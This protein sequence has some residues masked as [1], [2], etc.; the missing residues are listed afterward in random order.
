MVFRWFIAMYLISSLCLFTL[1]NG[2]DL[3]TEA[4]GVGSSLQ[5]AIND[6]KR[7]AV[8]QCIGSLLVSET[9]I[10]NFTL[11]KDIILVKTV[12]AVKRVEVLSETKFAEDSFSVRIRAEVST[13]SIREDLV[14][15]QILLES[16]NKPRLMVLVDE[17]DPSTVGTSLER[18]LTEKGFDL[19]DNTALEGRAQL[20]QNDGDAARVGELAGAEYIIT[21]QAE[22]STGTG[23]YGMISG[24]VILSVRI[25][26]CSTG[27]ILATESGDASFAHMDANVALSKA[28]ERVASSV[29]NDSLLDK[30]IVSFQDM[31]NNGVPVELVVQNVNNY[32]LK[33]HINGLLQTLPGVVSVRQNGFSAG[34]ASFT[35]Y[36]KG[37][38]DSLCGGLDGKSVDLGGT[39]S[40]TDVIG[41]R[42]MASLR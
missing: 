26:N 25:I 34:S 22:K 9:E 39:F 31:V 12:G 29:F 14:A 3:T 18:Y 4:D 5:A 40:I 7:S 32:G 27:K 28:S 13:G 42:V 33:N 19:L 20:L 1:G 2:G 11:K 38:V 41:S 35:V 37:A 8:E 10:E 21:G 16:M 23:V 15:M 6:A 24:K 36:Y 30:L 17:P